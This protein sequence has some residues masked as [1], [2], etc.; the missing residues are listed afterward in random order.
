MAE[1]KNSLAVVQQKLLNGVSYESLPETS[2]AVS[3]SFEKQFFQKSSYS[4]IQNEAICDFNTGA[5]FLNPRRSYLVLKVRS[6]VAAQGANFGQGS[7]C[8]LIKRVVITSRSGV[9]L[10]RTEDYN[11]LMA[12]V[13]RYGCP[14]DWLDKFGQLIGLSDVAAERATTFQQ[15]N[16]AA[17]TTFMIPLDKLS[18]FFAGDGKSLVPPPASAGLRVQISFADQ[19][20]ALVSDSAVQSYTVDDIYIMTNLTTM[21]DSWQKL[22]NEESATQGLTY[23]YPEWHTTQSSTAQASTNIE[24]RKAVAR[25]M[26]AFVITKQLPD[27]TANDNMKS[28]AYSVTSYQYR[29]GSLYPTQQPINDSKEAYYQAQSMWNGG[30]LDCKRPNAV[31][32]TRFNTSTAPATLSDGD[33]IVAV[34]LERSDTALNGVLNISGLPTNNSRVLGCDLTFSAGVARTNYLFMA[35]LR[36]AK[37]Y[38]DNA[39]I[40]E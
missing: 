22:I 6:T 5:K 37:F 32:F 26:S 20:Q 30:V 21:V 15:I 1:E 8:N 29:L 23:S 24:V 38:L 16:D 27:L 25:A 2:I 35:H 34:S 28:E 19:K 31:S 11:L 18:P 10:S 17:A 14:Q 4:P 33:G 9:E 7:V 40:S 13:L 12:K 3:R 39:I 36:V